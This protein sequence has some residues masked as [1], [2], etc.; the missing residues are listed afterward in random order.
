MRDF[1]VEQMGGREVFSPEPIGIKVGKHRFYVRATDA[2]GNVDSTEASVKIKVV[3]V[4][5]A[6]W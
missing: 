4:D 3:G 1:S 6:T 5:C 2:A